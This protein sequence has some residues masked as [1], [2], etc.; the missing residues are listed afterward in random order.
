MVDIKMPQHIE[1]VVIKKLVPYARNS[2]THSGGGLQFLDR[3]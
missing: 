3:C 2:R 1:Q